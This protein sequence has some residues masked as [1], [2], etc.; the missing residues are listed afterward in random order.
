MKEVSSLKKNPKFLNAL[1]LPPITQ[2]GMVVRDLGEGVE[3]YKHLL[4][5]RKWYR[6]R[7]KES[8]YVFK[9]K[10]IELS[11]D[12]AMGYSGKMQIELIHILG[13]DE[14]NVYFDRLGKGGEG[15]HHFGVMVRDLDADLR[16]ME[17]AGY[18]PLQTGSLRCEGGGFTRIGY[19]DTV[20]DAGFILELIETKAFGINLGM[21]Q[22]L[23]SLGRLTGDI[24]SMR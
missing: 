9:G 15:F 6:T 19:M 8:S 5:I 13:G 20:Q 23:V 21:P 3:Y 12:I 14:K 2:I 16:K 22:W 11:L 4:N 24:S 1:S 17:K 7:I 10:P 18:Q